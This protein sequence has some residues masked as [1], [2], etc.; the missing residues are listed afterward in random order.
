MVIAILMAAA[1]SSSDVS[2]RRR[3]S[4]GIFVI[5]VISPLFS[6][7]NIVEGRSIGDLGEKILN[8]A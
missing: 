8:K 6:V 7:M 3:E 5:V 1:T 2:R 4:F